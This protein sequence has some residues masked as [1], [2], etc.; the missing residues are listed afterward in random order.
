MFD[1]SFQ[2]PLA[3]WLLALIPIFIILYVLYIFWRRNIV[4]KI[5]DK[6]LVKELYNSFSSTKSFLKFL[7]LLIAFAC[8]VV[9]IA[10]PRV[11]EDGSSDVRSGID[12]VFALDLSNSMLATDAQPDRLTVAKNLIH[13]LIRQMPDNRFSIVGFAGKAYIQ[14]PLSFDKNS[15]DVILSAAHPTAIAA[16]G[17]SV[18]DAL[19]KT[20]L[21]LST[22]EDRYKTLILITDGETHDE[23]ALITAGELREKGIMINT[24]GIGSVGGAAIIDPSTGNPKR[25]AGGTV[26]ISKLNEPLLQQLAATT[27]GTYVYLND[28]NQAAQQIITHLSTADKKSFLDTSLLNYKSL[29]MW[30]SLP[31]LLLVFVEFFIPDKKKVKA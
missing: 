1:W 21:A 24:V 7:F 28:V 10:N 3:L 23:D 31:M 9:A 6:G 20:E 19:K 4:K 11:S 13:T 29:Y 26:I 16:Q 17:T 5:G 30:L 18:N 2:Y 25:D 12:I 14:M 27:N 22:S 8:G 15:A